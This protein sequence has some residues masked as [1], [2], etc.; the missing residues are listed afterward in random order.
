MKVIIPIKK[1][2]FF[3]EETNIVGKPDKLFGEII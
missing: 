3:G 1:P 2:D